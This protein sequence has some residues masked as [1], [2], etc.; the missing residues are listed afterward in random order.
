M[1]RTTTT[2][3]IFF[4]IL[5]AIPAFSQEVI[6]VQSCNDTFIQKQA[7]SLKEMYGKMGFDVLKEASIQMESEYEMPVIVPL[8]ERSL[9]QIIFIGDITSKLYELRIYDYDEKMITYQKKMWGDIDGN[10][11]SYQYSPK[12]TEFHMIKPVQVNKNK[13]KT[14]CGYVMLLKKTRI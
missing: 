13:K 6:R 4:T 10:I 7:D 3:L 12:F 14:L 9:Y 2:I 11:I 5:S 8:Q 1:K